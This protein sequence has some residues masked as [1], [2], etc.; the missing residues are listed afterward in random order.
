MY[1]I[2]VACCSVNAYSTSL[3]LFSCLSKC[4]ENYGIKMVY[5][6]SELGACHGSVSQESRIRKESINY[7]SVP[8]HGMPSDWSFYMN[9]QDNKRE[10]G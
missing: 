5:L 7:S 3:V 6:L 8:I 2:V 9:E 4:P 1:T 10:T